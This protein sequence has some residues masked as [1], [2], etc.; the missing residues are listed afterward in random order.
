M[1]AEWNRIESIKIQRIWLTMAIKSNITTTLMKKK[2]DMEPYHVSVSQF[3]ELTKGR[4]NI[5]KMVK[6][7]SLPLPFP[8]PLPLPSNYIGQKVL[9]IAINQ[10][11]LLYFIA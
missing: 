11:I 10:W 4:K 2:K 6:A 9:S 1:N 7:L 3:D 8:L 5:L